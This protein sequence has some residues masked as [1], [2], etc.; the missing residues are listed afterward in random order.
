MLT[1]GACAYVCVCVVCSGWILAAF[2]GVSRKQLGS[3][4]GGTQFIKHTSCTVL[5]LQFLGSCY[6]SKW[7]Y[8]FVSS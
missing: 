5:F 6:E 7:F 3:E 4:L 1:A 2:Y 8:S